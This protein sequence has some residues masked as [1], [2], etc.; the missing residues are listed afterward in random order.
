MF[1]RS[2]AAAI[3]AVATLVALATVGA[4]PLAAQEDAR[5]T[6]TPRPTPSATPGCI[7]TATHRAVP[8]RLAVGEETT[9]TVHLRKTCS[10]EPKSLHVTLVVDA[11]SAVA[12]EAMA[13]QLAAV[14][15]LAEAI[16]DPANPHKQVGVV[17]FG[18][19]NRIRC[20]LASDSQRMESCRLRLKSLIKRRHGERGPIDLARAI[21]DAQFEL[22][23]G[24]AGYSAGEIP[25]VMVVF[26]VG[27]APDPCHN[28]LIAAGRA[29][30]EGILVMTVCVGADCDAACVRQLA[31]SGRYF[32]Q[33]DNV[34]SLATALSKMRDEVLNIMIMRLTLTY[35]PAES[36]RLVPGSADP[37]A[38]VQ[39][40]GSRLDWLTN[41]VPR[42]GITAT[43]RLVPVTAGRIPLAREVGVSWVDY[44]NRPGSYTV[45]TA[46][47][48]V[49]TGPGRR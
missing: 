19:Q 20:P 37:E 42:D 41:Y 15:V 31:S 21:T 13:A 9:A 5:A 36:F 7:V 47:V 43:L 25:E 1:A 46:V 27:P 35:T 18:V 6:H 22:R 17:S 49:T 34:G 12:R 3:V 30:S 10:F 26:T 33:I 2:L 11:T 8:A 44:R 38:T 40:D 16:L 14:D 24:R 29:M 45:P 32:F 28:A 39:P 4:L 23:R 48:D